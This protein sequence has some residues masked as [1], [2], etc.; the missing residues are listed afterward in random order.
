MREPIRLTSSIDNPRKGLVRLW[1]GSMRGGH[2]TSPARTPP[3]QIV[4]AWLGGFLAIAAVAYLADA[5]RTPLLL[6]SFGASSVLLFGFPESPFSQPRSVIGG[7]FLS[8]LT[9]LV[10]I[11]LFGSTWWSTGLAL[12]TAISIMQITRTVHPPAGSNP[13]IIMLAHAGWPFLLR[14]TLF[15]VLILQATALLY[16]SF[17]KGRH[18]PMY[19]L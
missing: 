16:H 1:L 4:L 11:T 17:V 2:A 10:A 9:G 19:W 13:V 5:A 15:G 7:H 14:P 6:G 18:Y 12:A 8:S 3:A